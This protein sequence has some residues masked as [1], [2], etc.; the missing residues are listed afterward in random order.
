MRTIT[1]ITL[2]ATF[3]L[4]L[5]MPAMANPREDYIEDRLDD[6]ITYAEDLDYDVI[7]VEVDTIRSGESLYFYLEPGTYHAYAEGGTNIEDLD[8]EVLSERGRELGSD[9]LADNYPVVE[10]NLNDWQEVEFHL[11]VYEYQN[12]ENSGYYC[13]V[14]AREY[15]YRDRSYDSDWRD[16]DDRGRRD[17]DGWRDNDRRDRRH[18]RDDWDYDRRDDDDYW[19]DDYNDWYDDDRDDSYDWYGWRDEYHNWDWHFG[20]NWDGYCRDNDYGRGDGRSVVG[21]RLEDLYEFAWAR[22]HNP[23]MDDISR[24]TDTE[25][26]SLT[27]NRGYYVVF[28]SGSPNIDDLDLRVNLH[29]D[30]NIA[31]DIDPDAEP[32]VW[33][34]ISERATVEIEVEVWAF[35]DWEDSGY[36][37]LL[38][39]ER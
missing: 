8:M 21:D 9:F 24:I 26:Y 23:I 36:F 18:H 1:F 37:A 33:F 16:R 11:T 34:Y 10:F 19:D 20:Y 6:W 17:R 35:S 30:W 32:A 13:F 14:L 29:G 38:V 25:T 27:L 22:G 12:R 28:A 39:C 15:N 5:V 4:V 7:E 3:F 31:E 2:I